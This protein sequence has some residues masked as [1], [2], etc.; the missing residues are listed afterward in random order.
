MNY[1][2]CNNV[3][4]QDKDE[5][6]E[7][8]NGFRM[9]KNDM[10][11]TVVDQHEQNKMSKRQ[12]LPA[13]VDWRTSGCVTAIKNQVTNKYISHALNVP[14]AYRHVPYYLKMSGK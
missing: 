3:M 2:Y 4:T 8:M 6:N 7:K 11:R 13:S 9:S 1:D 14:S 10:P 5:F 12:T